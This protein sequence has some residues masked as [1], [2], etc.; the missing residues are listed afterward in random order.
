MPKGYRK[1][2]SKLGFQKGHT[3]WSKGT[4]T[5]IVPKT[6][7]KKGLLPWNKGKKWSKEAKRRMGESHTG[8]LHSNETKKKMSKHKIGDKNSQWKGIDASYSSFHKRIYTIKG[9][10]SYCEIC[11]TTKAKKFEW[12]NLTGKYNDVNDYKRM[13]SKCHKKY[14]IERK[15]NGYNRN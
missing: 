2:G 1:D 3:P 15:K 6:A 8:L 4:K 12:A 13:C 11:E 5:G 10:P 14:D 7:F 9:A